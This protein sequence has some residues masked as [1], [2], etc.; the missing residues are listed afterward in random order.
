MITYQQETTHRVIVKGDTEAE[1]NAECDKWAAKG[2][3]RS[4]WITGTPWEM[5]FVCTEAEGDEVT[6]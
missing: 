1:R 6:L 2:Y 3:K 5:I 4:I